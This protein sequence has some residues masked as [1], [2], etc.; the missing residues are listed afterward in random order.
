MD[1]LASSVCF[2]MKIIN[3]I[4]YMM[5][6]IT[7]IMLSDRVHKILSDI[8]KITQRCTNICS[9]SV[10][11]KDLDQINSL[12]NIILD[13]VNPIISEILSMPGLGVILD[14]HSRLE[15]FTKSLEESQKISHTFSSR[16][17]Y[18]MDVLDWI[19][20]RRNLSSEEI[21]HFNLSIKTNIHAIMCIG[22]TQH[23]LYD[24]M[25]TLRDYYGPL[26]MSNIIYVRKIMDTSIINLMSL[27]NL[28]SDTGHII[29][30]CLLRNISIPSSIE[31]LWM[32]I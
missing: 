31:E 12:I 20:S 8:K 24:E 7:D 3:K 32:N 30:V 25:R 15:T 18:S 28:L 17:N 22:M 1:L 16:Y 13:I 9:S 21:K 26:T 6:N 14:L 10:R 23:P 4:M 2:T 11:D 5:T 19:I 29:E 27:Y